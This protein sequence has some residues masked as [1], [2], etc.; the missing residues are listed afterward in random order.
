MM[1]D[2]LPSIRH[3][4]VNLPLAD[5]PHLIQ[6]RPF[7]NSD[8]PALV[9][10]WNA[11][12]A[13]KRLARKMNVPTFEHFVLAKPYF[14]REGVLIAVHDGRAIGVVHAG[15]GPNESHIAVDTSTGVICLLNILPDYDTA[16]LRAQLLQ[17]A[18]AYLSSRGVSQIIGGPVSPFTSFYH[19]LSS[20]GESAGVLDED[21]PTQEAFRAAGYGESMRNIVLQRDLTAF[22]PAFDR[23]QRAIQHN[24]DVVVDLDADLSDWWELCRYGPLPRCA[25]DAI[26][27]VSR[28]KV[29]RTIWWDQAFTGAALQSSVSFSNVEVP[30]S[31]RRTGIGTLL[32]NEA[33]KQLKSSGA[34]YATAQVPE[35]NGIALS[36]FG[37]LGFTE[38]TRGTTFSKA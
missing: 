4:Q 27:R 37:S 30:E 22:R 1:V 18:E 17:A 13:A 26:E 2:K 14:D 24:F 29:A 25:F 32:M 7:L 36:F 23:K 31:R 20:I 6:I 15:F 10:I 8:P 5:R 3:I 35:T 28:E 11:Q 38:V 19:G 33:M 34:F 21:Q 12:P 16:E 9:A